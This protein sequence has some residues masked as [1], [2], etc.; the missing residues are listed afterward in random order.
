D[1]ENEVVR[2]MMCPLSLIGEAKSS[3]DELNEGTI[4]TWDEL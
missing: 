3:V 1:T 4:K 2:L